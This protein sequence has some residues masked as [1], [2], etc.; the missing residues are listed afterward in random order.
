[1]ISIRLDSHTGLRGILCVWVMIFHCFLYCKSPIDL[2]GSSL[3]PFFFLLSGYTLMVATNAKSS[4]EASGSSVLVPQ[5]GIPVHQ[6]N[7]VLLDLNKLDFYR[8]RFVRAFP[9]YYLCTAFALPLWFCGFGSVDPSKKAGIVLSIV[10]SIIPLDTLFIFLLG[11]PIDGPGWTICTLGI[12]WL[13]FPYSY[14]HIKMQSNEQLL[15]NI[16]Y[17]YYIQAILVFIVFFVLV[18]FVG[19][20]PAFCGATMNP[21]VRYPV[22]LMGMYAGELCHRNILIKQ[23]PWPKSYFWIL[24]I[25][26]C[27]CKYDLLLPRSA[28]TYPVHGQQQN[29]YQPQPFLSQQHQYQVQPQLVNGIPQYVLI[30]HEAIDSTPTPIPYVNNIQNTQQVQ[31]NHSTIPISNDASTHTQQ[32]QVQSTHSTIPISNDAS[33]HTHVLTAETI[34]WNRQ[35]DINMCVYLLLTLIV[36]IL[37]TISRYQDSG[38]GILGSLWLQAIVPFLQLEI[39]VGLTMVD[40]KSSISGRLLNNNLIQW[41]GALSMTIYLIHWVILNYLCFAVNGTS[42]TWPT[43]FNCDQYK[44][45]SSSEYSDCRDELNHFNHARELPM[46][47]IPVV[48]AVTMVV[49]IIIFY[50]FEEPIRRKLKRV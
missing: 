50:G 3:M 34:Y 5:N 21:I 27:C 28:C 30:P 4:A 22:F 39:L 10:T 1:M 8:N 38:T 41:L 37:D 6:A 14:K 20:W 35:T 42:L 16:V 23:L 9:T 43:T 18:N 25:S 48:I 36:I 31:S 17:Y 15:Q 44:N 32:V 46:W 7:G 40:I 45:Q 13:W 24:P 2:Q 26:S 11:L 29:M 33:T 47:G 49:S 19:G 12:M